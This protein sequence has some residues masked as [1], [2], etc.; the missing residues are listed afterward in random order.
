MCDH[1]R[2]HERQD[3]N[4]RCR[5]Q[6][7]EATHDFLGV[8]N[9]N[10]LAIRRRIDLPIP[11]FTLRGFIATLSGAVILLL[12]L[13]PLAFHG[14]HWIRVATIPVAI[15]TRRPI[16]WARSLKGRPRTASMA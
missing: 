9:S 14:V 6:A 8:Y 3:A 1:D 10:A 13:A 7:D 12:L 15:P 4:G 5:T 11:V 2:L 16:S